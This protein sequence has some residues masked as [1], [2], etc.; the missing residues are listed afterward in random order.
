MQLLTHDHRHLC[1][2]ARS[3]KFR[4]KV[5]NKCPIYNRLPSEQIQVSAVFITLFGRSLLTARGYLEVE[6]PLLRR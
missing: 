1:K 4:G 6:L 3:S 5:S 2:L